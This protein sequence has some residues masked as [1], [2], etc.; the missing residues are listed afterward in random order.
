MKQIKPKDMMTLVNTTYAVEFKSASCFCRCGL[1]STNSS[2]C[3]HAQKW[4]TAFKIDLAKERQEYKRIAQSQQWLLMKMKNSMTDDDNA[5]QIEN[6]VNRTFEENRSFQ[7]NHSAIKRLLMSLCKVYESIGYVQGMN[8]VAAVLVYHAGEE[9]A[10]ALYKVIMDRFNLKRVLQPGFP[11]LKA[12]NRSIVKLGTQR[13]PELFA[14]LNKLDL[15][16]FLFTTE[17]TI[18]I[19]LSYVPLSLSGE[20]LDL[21]FS[22][23]WNYY[24]SLVL[25]IFAKHE[26]RIL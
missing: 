8:Y 17:W 6:D 26:Q 25:C 14:H 10:Y 15:P 11:G 20:Y 1:A 2:V 3:L 18:C 21:F 12:H 16:V 22:K 4:L 13:L 9:G 19:L 5:K 7:E 24:Y 23:G